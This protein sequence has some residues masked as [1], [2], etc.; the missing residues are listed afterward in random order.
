[1]NKFAETL[2]NDVDALI[3]RLV[4]GTQV[5]SPGADVSTSTQYY[6]LPVKQTKGGVNID[7]NNKPWVVGSFLPSQYI[8]ETHP[9]GHNGVDL[10]APRGT[11]IY[12]I[13]PGEVIST[14]VQPKGGNT[15]KVSH[16]DGAVVSYYAHMDSVNVSVGDQVD[17]NTVLGQMG[18]SGNAKGRGAHLHYEVSVNGT[19]VDPQKIVGKQIG[20][21]S[22]KALFISKLMME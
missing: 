19:K 8:N 5:T 22:K 7:E 3:N 18:D 20:S 9:S 2:E 15:V 10:K 11:S 14:A 6:Q 21:L 4:G 13:G 16:E 17:F 1:M 12:P